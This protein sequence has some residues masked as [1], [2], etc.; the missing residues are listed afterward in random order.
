MAAC[1]V[2]GGRQP[3]PPRAQPARRRPCPPRRRHAVEI[4]GGAFTMG[5]DGAD[6]VPAMARARRGGVAARL[7][8][9]ADDRH[10]RRVRRLRAGDALRH[11]R[12]ALGSSFVFYLQA[13]A[14]RAAA[15]GRS[16]AACRGGCRSPMHVAA[17]R[18]PGLARPRAART[19]RSCTSPGTTR[20]RIARGR[21]RG[22]RPRPNGS[23]P[24]AAASK[25]GASP[26]ATN[27]SM[28]D[29]V[30]RCNVLR[31]AFPNAPAD[32][33]A[34]GHR[35][36]AAASRTASASSTSAATSGNG[37]PMV[38]PGLSPRDGGGRP[39]CSRD[40]GPALHARRLVPLPRLL[41]Q[42]LP[43]RGARQHARQ[44]AGKFG[45]RVAADGR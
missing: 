15:R 21:A 28:R 14:R 35:A 17:A 13:A 3:A 24:R 39:R 6:A 16:C 8:D 40:R 18:G 10:Q 43:G 1:C 34:A 37:A 2:P 38:Q 32:G 12:R 23:A 7:R 33:L 44:P 9:R 45:F 41:L 31:G 30:P 29:G 19:I 4:A 42:P 20:R 36:A 22:C 26:G 11:R 27:C 5:N 25:A